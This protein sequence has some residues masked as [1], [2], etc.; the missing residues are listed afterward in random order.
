M[1]DQNY[2]LI[3]GLIAQNSALHQVVKAKVEGQDLARQSARDAEHDSRQ[4]QDQI[5]HLKTQEF[6][7]E[8]QQRDLRA[9]A[10]RMEAE[11][12]ILQEAVAERDAIILEWM[13]SNEAFKR[14]ALQYGKN[15][16]LDKEH[17]QNELDENFL[18]IAEEDPDFANTK[19]TQGAKQRLGRG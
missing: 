10:N 4:A 13:Q 9:Y 8:L 2:I 1:T 16:G 18:D 17:I 5:R 19:K 7:N 11:N 12:K 15:L 3:N 6:L 14:L